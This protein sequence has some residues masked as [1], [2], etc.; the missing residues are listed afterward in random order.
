M[1][2]IVVVDGGLGDD[3]DAT[4]VGGGEVGESPEGS[5]DGGHALIEV[6]VKSGARD[7][8]FER[9]EEAHQFPEGLGEASK[10]RAETETDHSNG[11]HGD[12]KEESEG[13]NDGEKNEPSAGGV[14]LVL[15][16]EDGHVLLE[17]MEKRK[18]LGVMELSKDVLKAQ[19]TGEVL[20]VGHK[21]GDAL[22]LYS[23]LLDG[24]VPIPEVGELVAGGTD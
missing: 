16:R 10:A 18:M 11:D 13:A 9:G 14:V 21:G 19:G 1:A 23:Q 17:L 15:F 3:S 6:G 22:G 7:S 8:C 2:V 24:A 20:E 5:V 12:E 4:G